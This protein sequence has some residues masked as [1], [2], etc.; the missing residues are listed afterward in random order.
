[1]VTNLEQRVK[2]LESRIFV[3][4]DEQPEGVFCYCE[5]GRKDAPPPE[6]VKGWRHNEHRIMRIKGET[7]EALSKRAIA[8]VKPSMAKNAVP[9]FHSIDEWKESGIDRSSKG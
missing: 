3:D 2:T 4:V 1:V 6:P 8:Q 5:D 9:V 7:D